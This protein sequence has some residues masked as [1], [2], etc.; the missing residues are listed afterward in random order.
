M[1]HL[2]MWKKSFVLGSFTASAMQVTSINDCQ[3]KLYFYATHLCFFVQTN[4][5][6]SCKTAKP[7]ALSD[8][9]YHGNREWWKHYQHEVSQSNIICFLSLTNDEDEEEIWQQREGRRRKPP[10]GWQRILLPKN[11]PFPMLFTYYYINLIMHWGWV[12][13]LHSSVY[14][15][16]WSKWNT[17]PIHYPPPQSPTFLRG[18]SDNL[19]HE[20]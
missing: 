7:E 4:V 17:I 1:H 18:L 10:P 14:M 6:F 13:V 8:K 15:F 19:E 16:P 3:G 11:S 12:K 9:Y 2:G 20:S 5:T